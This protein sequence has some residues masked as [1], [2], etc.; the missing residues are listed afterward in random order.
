MHS[1]THLIKDEIFK[2]FHHLSW[3]ED[4]GDEKLYKVCFHVTDATICKIKHPCYVPLR[5]PVR[6]IESHKRRNREGLI[7]QQFKNMIN[8][9]DKYDPFYLFIDEP[10]RNRQIDEMSEMVNH[11]LETDLPVLTERNTH[12]FEITDN[13]ILN[14]PNWIMDFY[15]SRLARH[16]HG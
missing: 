8:I 11:K 5:H 1:G 14:T 7:D 2:D 15:A 16:R 13:R 12:D 4:I 6:I 9:V 3:N 10:I